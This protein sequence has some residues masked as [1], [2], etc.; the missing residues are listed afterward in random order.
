MWLLMLTACSPQIADEPVDQRTAT[1]VVL[2]W[3]RLLLDLERHTAGYRP[4]VSARAFAYVE[5]AAYEAALPAMNG[6]VSLESYCPGYQSPS[7]SLNDDQYYLPAALNAVYARILHRFFPNAPKKWLDKIDQLETEYTLKLQK[8]I[9]GQSLNYSVA[10]GQKVAE[11]V[12]LWSVTDRE[13]HNAFLSN[14]DENYE[15]PACRGCW[16]PDNRHPMPALLPYWRKVRG[17]VVQAEDLR[18]IPPVPFDETPGSAFFTEAMEVFSVSQPLS[19]EN[20]WIAELWSDDLPGLTVT[21]AGRWISIANQAIEQARPPF[22][23]VVETYLKTA[24]ALCDASIVVWHSKYLYNVERPESYIGRNIKSGWEALHENPSF[25]SYPSGHSAFGAAAAEVLSAQ[26]GEHFQLTD[27]T[28]EHRQE[29]VGKPRTYQSFEEM[30]KENAASRVLIG[31]HYRM[32]C[33]EG[34]RLGK[35]VGRKVANLPLRH[36]EEAGI[37]AR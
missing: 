9:D 1:E 18:L 7:A 12:W 3:N 8:Q 14:H 17:F 4:P 25:P 13:G 21:P 37:Q 30:A 34:L 6:Y 28:H 24:M 5:M 20:I 23:I 27:R 29:F 22:S 19:R 15:P 2:E 33:E 32:D 26:L 10:F 16:Q 35:I 11:A 31:V 36:K